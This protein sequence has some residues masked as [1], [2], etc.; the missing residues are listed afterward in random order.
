MDHAR[1][2]ATVTYRTDNG[3]S[4][5][6]HHIE[7]LEELH[8]LIERG[9]DWNAILKIEI[10]LNPKRRLYS[11]TVEQSATRSAQS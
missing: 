3:P 11:D 8:D 9:P 2:I 6:D 4:D 5:V 7:E 10:V 1:W